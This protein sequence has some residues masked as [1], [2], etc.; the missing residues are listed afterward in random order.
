MKIPTKCLQTP[1]CDIYFVFI[2]VYLDLNL[3]KE[4]YFAGKVES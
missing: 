2:Y 3:N 1:K 4:F